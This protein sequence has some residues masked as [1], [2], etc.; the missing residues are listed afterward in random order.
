MAERLLTWCDHLDTPDRV[1]EPSTAPV[2]QVL[3][4][5]TAPPLRAR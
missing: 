1:A 3:V 2:G 5:P 4:V